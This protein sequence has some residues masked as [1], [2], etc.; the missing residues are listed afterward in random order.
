MLVDT[1]LTVSLQKTSP[2]E[3]EAQGDPIRAC[4]CLKGGAGRTGPGSAQCQDKRLWAQTGTQEAL[5][6]HHKALY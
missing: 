3:E 2:G 4:Q 5:S 6:K 1:K